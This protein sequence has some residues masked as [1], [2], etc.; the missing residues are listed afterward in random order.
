MSAPVMEAVKARTLVAPAFFERL[1]LRVAKTNDLDRET[2]EA[3]TEQALAYLATSA[4]K[5][6]GAPTLYMSADVDPAWHEFM[7]YTRQYDEFFAS[8]GWPKVHHNPCDGYGGAVYP[9]A[10]EVLPLTV[11]AIQAAGYFVVPE[12]WKAAVDC[13]DTCGDDGGGGNPLPTCEHSI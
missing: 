8:H 12:L 10:A 7:T 1:C 6:E 13:E 11:A 4:Q 9:P 5:P 2:A 3:I